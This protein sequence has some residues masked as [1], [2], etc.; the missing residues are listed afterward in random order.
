MEQI[1]LEDF[2]IE[3]LQNH[4]KSL[5]LNR[6]PTDLRLFM[7][8]KPCDDTKRKNYLIDCMSHFN[9]FRELIYDLKHVQYPAYIKQFE[10]LNGTDTHS[11]VKMIY[12]ENKTLKE[13]IDKMMRKIDNLGQKMNN[14]HGTISFSESY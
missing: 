8:L 6:Q 4:I 12:L 13:E 11:L 3:K 5:D 2:I 9:Q 7:E 1:S 10:A 14:L